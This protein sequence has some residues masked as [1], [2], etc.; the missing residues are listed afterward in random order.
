[1]S[2]GP[3]WYMHDHI[4]L[5]ALRREGTDLVM[6]CSSIPYPRSPTECLR[7]SYFLELV[8]KWDK[9]QGPIHKTLINVNKK[10]SDFGDIQ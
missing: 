8:Q 10:N 7:D 4:L 6:S 2:S 1:M 3:T 9:P 5:F